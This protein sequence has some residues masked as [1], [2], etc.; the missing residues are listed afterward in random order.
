MET[1]VII[2]LMA[3]WAASMK[4]IEKFMINNGLIKRG[5]PGYPLNGKEK[6]INFIL[7]VLNISFST[8]VFLFSFTVRNC[9]L[10]WF[11]DFL[12]INFC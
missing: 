11:D 5:K 12:I 10:T 9:T 1:L 7:H 2:I 4:G 6:F 3:F 8:Y